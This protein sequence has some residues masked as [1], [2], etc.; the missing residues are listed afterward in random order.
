MR[1]EQ[2]YY[3][4]EIAKCRSISQAAKN[5]FMR[6]S[7]LSNAIHALENEWQQE[8]F[9][10]SARGV[11]LTPFGENILPS[12][13][14]MIQASESINALANT[15]HPPRRDT[16]FV[17]A[18]PVGALSAVVALLARM[19]DHYPEV[20]I[21]VPESQSENIVGDLTA[22]GS[23]IGVV[24]A[25]FLA[26]S[27][28]KRNAEN[29]GLTVEPVYIDSLSAFVRPD[30]PLAT[31]TL[32]TL[33]ELAQENTLIYRLYMQPDTNT[34]YLDFKKFKRCYVID[35][36]ELMKK[37]ARASRMIAIAPDLAFAEES[38]DGAGLVRIPISDLSVTLTVALV[39][40]SDDQQRTTFENI[41]LD[42]LR[43]YY[44]HQENRH[45][46]TV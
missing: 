20:N 33:E 34:F 21:S 3:F 24:A 37:T 44:H 17:Y 16:L 25:G 9:V 5:L 22:A 27:Y 10:R 11:S 8:L 29:H 38:G 7:T 4:L 31:R 12:V 35:S 23:G 2:L 28:M 45:K 30:H 18:Y 32:V 6:K 26:Y 1:I 42:V 19:H 15:E 40:K 39:Y 14:Q 43:D 41:A 13:E 46:K 36:Y